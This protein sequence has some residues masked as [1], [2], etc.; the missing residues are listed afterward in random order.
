M[1]TSRIG[2]RP[3]LDLL[4]DGGYVVAAPSMHVSDA[5]YTF[6]GN[7]SIGLAPM[8]E[9]LREALK[10]AGKGTD[11][12]RIKEEPQDRS[13]RQQAKVIPEGERNDTLTS[14]GG[15]MR[16]V[17][18][19]RTAIGAALHATNRDLCD[20]PLD[21]EEVGRIIKSVVTRYAPG[22]PR[23]GGIFLPREM[24]GTKG[25]WLRPDAWLT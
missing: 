13:K 22:V 7:D 8:P 9:G 15:T 16:S 19:G 17:G 3:G 21:E 20:P 24:V 11:D 10:V 5:Q 23:A 1:L 18:F 6:E 12:S 2:F 4:S 14:M 25:P